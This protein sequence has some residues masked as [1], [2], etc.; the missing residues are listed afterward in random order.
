MLFIIHNETRWN[1]YFKAMQR[2]KYFITKKR[3]ELKELFEHFG[4]AYFRPA[5]EE[6]VREYVKVMEPI[7]E[8]LDVLQADVKISIGYLLPTLTILLQKMEHLKEKGAI[9]HCKPLLNTMIESVKRRFAASLVDEEL[10]I[11]AMVHP[12]FKAKW[13]PEGEERDDNIQRLIDVFRS[14]KNDHVELDIRYL[15][16]YTSSL[17]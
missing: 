2:V 17:M 10:L 14:F 4:I 9:K 7:S 8:A 12:L 6:F 3:T 16:S 13:I 11:A 15:Y 5:E 1:S